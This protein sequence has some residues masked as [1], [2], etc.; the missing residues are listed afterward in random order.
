MLKISKSILERSGILGMS[1]EDIIKDIK[2]AL[3]KPYGRTRTN[4]EDHVND[5]QA[6]L[7]YNKYYKRI[8]DLQD[9]LALTEKAFK[10]AVFELD[11]YKNH[12]QSTSQECL[13]RIERLETEIWNKAK[14]MMKSE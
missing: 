7:V 13:E 6:E 10:L 4:A 14:E 1:R 5:I 9:Q 2:L 11:F 8:A 12:S 3:T